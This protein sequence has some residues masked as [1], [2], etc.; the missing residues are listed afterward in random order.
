MLE[1]IG[2]LL[3]ARYRLEAELGRG[4]MGVVYR[5]HDTLLGR[6]VAVKVLSAT[7][8]GTE[9][10]AH[11]L[12]EAQAAAVLN[13]PNIVT[14]HDVGEA[15]AAGPAGP[16]PF[17]VMELV[18]GPSLHDRRPG[19]LE[20]TVAVARQVCA[21][22]E[23]AHARG[24]IH[25]DLKPENVLLSLGPQSGTGSPAGTGPLAGTGSPAG[26]G[27]TA[28]LSDFGLARSVASR[29]S[30]EGEIV[31]T[32]FYLAPELALGQAYDGR[33]D[34]YALGVML[35][36]LTT[37]RLPFLA[38]DP[39]AVISQHLHAPAVPPRA[40]DEGIPPALDALILRLLSKDPQD[41][42]VSA[43]EVQRA[44]E[45][46][47]ILDREAVP[48]RELSILERIER[49][50]LVGRER[51]LA[52]TRALWQKAVGG[53]GQTLLISGEPGIGKTRLVREL[54]TRVQV[55]GGWVLEGEC[56]QEG[57]GPYAPFAQILRR[58]FADGTED[59]FG[60]PDFV[61]AD[62]LTL[63]PALRLR[64]PDLPPN[65]P[66]DP[67][68][69]QLRLF[70][71]VVAFCAALSE[72]APL[73]L[74]LED[75]H[76]AD[77]GTL[78][79]LRHLARRTRQQR[80]MIVA[81]YREVELDAAHPLHEVLL[82]LERRR[83]ATRLKLMRL[84]REGTRD[85]LAALL[86]ED[87]TEELLDGIHRETEGN[88]F[89]IEE[90]CKAIVESGQLRFEGGRWHRPSVEELGIPQSVRLAIQS[91]VGRLPQQVRDTLTLA[92]VVGREF[93]FDTLIAT[94]FAG[95]DEAL[96]TA[97]ERSEHAQLISELSGGAG[98]TFSFTHALI[99]AT[100]AEGLSGLRR[101]RLHRRVAEAIETLHPHDGGRVGSL[102]H[103]Y[104]QAGVEDKAVHYLA[105][106]G[107]HARASYANQDAIRYYSQALEYLPG[108][109]PRRL[110]LLAAR[111]Q[112]YDLVADWGAQR[113][114]LEAMLALARALGDD[115]R[116]CDAL[117]ALA[118]C[119]HNTG[120]P[121]C[122]EPAE[123]A[124]EVAR[125]MGDALR[126]G[127]ALRFLGA[128]DYATGHYARSRSTLEAA[129][130]RLQE[131]AFPGES[132][133]CLSLLSVTLGAVNEPAA[134]LEAAERAAALSR[135]AGDR[136]QEAT[137]LRRIA[138]IHNR[139][140]E[141]AAA[142]PAVEAALTLHREIG[143]RREECH[144]LSILGQTLGR[145]GRPEKAAEAFHE[146][147][148]IAEE[149]GAA[150]N[151]GVGV[152]YMVYSV[153]S[154]QG[155]YEVGLAFLE[156]WV[157]KM[158]QAKEEVLAAQFEVNKAFL[159]TYLGQLEPALELAQSVLLDADR[160]LNYGY[161]MMLSDVIALCQG[162]LGHFRQAR[163][164]CRAAIERAEQA[165][166]T[167]DTVAWLVGLAYVA[168]LEGDRAKLRVG[169]E[170]VQQYGVSLPADNA[171]SH[172]LAARM[173]LALGEAELALESSSKVMQQK[174][175]RGEVSYWMEQYYLTHARVLRTLGRDAEADDYLQRAYE[176]VML[177]AS[178]TQDERLRRGWLENVPDNREIVAEWEG[179]HRP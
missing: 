13:H 71:N 101:R 68:A 175:L 50:R 157:A 2:T 159:L 60:L 143:D 165:G 106:A 22:L 23:H 100:L 170:R 61:L 177:V 19:S 87:I 145:L 120:I 94:G 93:D 21:A 67:K 152:S 33:A 141:Y 5:A 148:Q 70:E 8:L 4:G 30:V 69:E 90:V 138:V 122:R 47:D 49:G 128:H 118:D 136:R 85:M 32:V 110:D 65:P 91:R 79:L 142:L 11:L 158:R 105:K 76:W 80:V 132:A 154:P 99:P 72:R 171:W 133:A 52:Q 89:F 131:A 51:E 39:L 18:E 77:G 144:G 55:A 149:I 16:M 173:H 134:A 124:V 103:H 153:L 14:V 156:S 64:Y 137:S 26:A 3:N 166:E 97:L 162:G 104:S 147:L 41:R 146:M 129:L 42:P 44:L 121:G 92:A 112:V 126:E 167:R 63:S 27:V 161:Q 95:G 73:L 38:D 117:T 88:P 25:R 81:T 57:F 140:G 7:V 53:E 46:P 6:D 75:A 150:P 84:G 169:T 109:A 164:C 96:V 116:H 123:R 115:A 151:V 10:R 35:Y 24:I 107:D 86:A 36:E 172:H 98:G 62:L 135:K 78:S 155:E 40:R 119:L 176:R 178:K 56:Y 15:D 74:V 179:R 28:K 114:D 127:R 59:G 1:A 45:A 163:E 130:A 108:D 48:A 12:R 29:L 34:L 174:E 54:V 9:G 113:T 37:G 168:C 82:D 160:L 31:G 83:L 139:Q 58:A 20:E 111:A 17:I 102:A 43:A 125:E 66:L